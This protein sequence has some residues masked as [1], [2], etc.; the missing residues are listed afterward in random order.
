MARDRERVLCEG[1]L[2]CLN[3]PVRIDVILKQIE[4]LIDLEQKYLRASL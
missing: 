2:H 3:K 1:I 4:M